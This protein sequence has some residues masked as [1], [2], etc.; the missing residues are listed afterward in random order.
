MPFDKFGTLTIN[1]SSAGGAYPLPDV[2]VRVLGVSEENGEIEY[3]RLTDEDGVINYITLPAPPRE[4]SQTP[5]ASAPPYA[6]YNVEAAIPGYYP[7]R[8][9]NVPVF[10]G[11]VTVL[12]INMIPS[13]IHSGNAYTPRNN[14]NA[15]VFENPVLEI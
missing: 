6:L 10:D 5:G 13:S 15:Y 11:E 7:K 2:V 14:L 8:I 1:A 9:Y 3:S 12:P 4:L